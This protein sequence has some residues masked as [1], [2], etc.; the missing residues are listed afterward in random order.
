[1]K[2]A[3]LLSGC[4]VYD[5]SEIHESVFTLLSLAQEGHNYTCFA[6]NKEQHH[7]VNHISGEEMSEN[8]NCMIE[9]ARISRGQIEDVADL[10]I[11]NFDALAIV[12][13]FGAGKNINQWAISGKDG[14]I[15]EVVKEKIV[16]VLKN[17]KKI[18]AM[19]MGPTVVASALHNSG[20]N[21]VLSVGTSK[22]SSPYDIGG[23]HEGMTQ[24]G[25]ICKEASKTEIVIDQDLGII[26]VPAYMMDAEINEVYNNIHQGIK[27]LSTI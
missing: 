22:E 7:T 11:A 2:V 25:A 19:C 3:V 14:N 24:L 21:P 8:R 27:A 15:D 6:P 20:Y 5:G 4:G 18:L 1:M 9:S 17:G 23:I 16:S 12:G 13:G 26:S 10:N